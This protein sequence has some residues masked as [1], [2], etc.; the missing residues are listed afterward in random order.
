MRCSTLPSPSSDTE[1]RA[2]DPRRGARKSA[3]RPPTDEE[4]I[5]MKLVNFYAADGIHAGL[6]RPGGVEDLA[7]SGVWQGRAPVAQD[8]IRQLGKCVQ[9]SANALVPLE[10]LRLAPSVVSSEKL[11]CVGINY[12][13][14]AEE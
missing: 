14:H 5:I 12:R 2:D 8:E 7:A 13:R 3:C 1:S 4:E 9:R 6:V 11:I 10:S